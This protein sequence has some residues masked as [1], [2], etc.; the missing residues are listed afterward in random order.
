ME[1][2]GT[3][4]IVPDEQ[5]YKV[6]LLTPDQQIKRIVIFNGNKDTQLNLGDWFSEIEIND[7]NR[8]HTEVLFSDKC[9]HY[10]DTVRTIKRKVLGE[11]DPNALSYPE[12]YL[13]TKIKQDID[14]FH[15]YQTIT[16][17]DKNY[18]HS[19][20]LG[21]L[22]QN[23]HLP[24]EVTLNTPE[25]ETY[26][27]DDLLKYLPVVNKIHDVNIPIG[28]KFS[29]Y[30]DLLYSA[31]PFDI[32]SSTENPFTQTASNNLITY[33]KDLLLNYG[34]IVDNILYVCLIDDVIQYADEIGIGI[35]YMIQLYYPVMA[36][37]NVHSRQDIANLKQQLL[38][39]DQTYMN[40]AD[41][42]QYNA[43]I[44][45]LYKIYNNRK[46]NSE[47]P[48]IIKG[49]TEIDMTMHPKTSTI[50]P[51]EVI[52]KNIHT[53]KTVPFIKYNPGSRQENIYRLYCNK[54]SKNGK[55]IPL[56]KKQQIINYS[57][58]GNAREIFL[59]VKAVC[60]DDPTD[61]YIAINY[62]GNIRIQTTFVHHVST[63]ALN[64]FIKD[65]V[66]QL[67]DQF[68]VSLMPSGY[69]I[70][71]FIS[72]EDEL[73]EIENMQYAFEMQP[74]NSSLNFDKYLNCLTNIFEII[75]H[76]PN[77]PLIMNYKR[78]GNYAKMNSM[79][80]MIARVYTTTNSEKAVIDALILNFDMTEEQSLLEVVKFLNDFNQIN[81][82]YVNKSF[83]ILENQGFHTLLRNFKNEAKL[84]FTI[85]NINNIGF[86]DL[87]EI[88]LDSIFRIMQLPTSTNVSRDEIAQICLKK[89][90]I[91]QSDKDVAIIIPQ[92]N[93][94]VLNTD[95]KMRAEIIDEEDDD[96][97]DDAGIIFFDEEYEEDEDDEVGEPADEGPSDANDNV[98]EA[99]EVAEEVTDDADQEDMYGGAKKTFA[100]EET[101]PSNIFYNKMRRLDSDLILARKEGQFKA[102]SR[103]C[104]ANV[105]RQPIILT[106]DEKNRIDNENR[107]AYGYAMRYGHNTD[108]SKQNWFICPRYWCMKTNLPI[109][110]TDLEKTIKEG[111]CAREDIH[112]FTDP[113]YHIRNG[114]YVAHNPGLIKN[115]HPNNKGIPC[116]FGK[117]WDSEQLKT[118]RLKYG[119][120]E[121]D[122][123]D[124]NKQVDNKIQPPTAVANVNEFDNSKYYI[125]G[126][127]KYPI[128]NGRWGFLPPSVQLFLD[129]NYADVI[130]KKNAA[131]IKFNVNTFLRYGVEQSNHQ[132]FIG[133]IADIYAA[134]SRIKERNEA[135]PTIKRM[136][137][138][139]SKSIT[140][141]MYLQYQNGSLATL[142]QPKKNK[143]N[144]ELLV[145]YET[146]EFYKSLVTTDESQMGFFEET[147]GSF[148]NFLKYLNDD[149]SLIDHTYLWDIVT[150]VNPN[151]FPSGLNL[152]LLQIADNDI[153]DNVELICPTNS[154]MSNM[155]DPRRETVIILKHDTF[156]EPV[157]MYKI[158]K[159][160]EKETEKI[161]NT[162][163]TFSQQTA[164]PSLKRILNVVQNVMGK[165]CKARPSKPKEFIYKTNILAGDLLRLLKL[166]NYKVK[167]QVVNYRGKVIGLM[168][169][170]VDAKQLDLF[171][172]C[173]PSGPIKE[174]PVKY[175]DHIEWASY[176]NTRNA[177]MQVSEESNKSILS[178]P[179]LKVVEDELIVGILTETNQF[180]QIDPPISNDI[181][182]GLD[183]LYTTG[184]IN[185]GY[186]TADKELATNK[187]EDAE[188]LNTIHQINLEGQFYSAFRTTLRLA[189]NKYQNYEKRAQLLKLIDNK[190]YT[191]QH[192]LTRIELLVRSVL[193]DLVTFAEFNPDVLSTI[194]DISEIENKFVKSKYCIEIEDDNENCKLVIPKLNLVTSKENIVLYFKRIS[195][196]LLRYKRVRM[197]ILEPNKYLNI[198]SLD[199]KLNDNELLLIQTLLD[200]NYFDDL[201]EL[202][203][204]EYIDNITYDIAEPSVSQKYS[205]NISLNQQTASNAQPE[206]V[207]NFIIDCVVETLPNVIGNQTSYW[208]TV[209]PNKS[210]EVVFNNSTNCTYYVLCDII[211]KHR[212]KFVSIPFIKTALCQKY[213][214]HMETY[215]SQI[216]AILKSQHGKR[217]M[218][219]RVI[220]NQIKL[221]DLI[222]SEEYYITNL[223]L[224]AI[225]SH[226][227]LPIL[228]FS[229]KTLSNLG[230]G[231]QWV[232]L[233]GKRDVDN[234]YC[235]RSPVNNSELPEYHMITPAC[236]L[237][238][239]KGF[240]TMINNTDYIENN[241]SFETYLK[242]Y[243]LTADA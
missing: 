128:S 6:Y 138:I 32:L 156:Y 227:G 59:L 112:E 163:E 157:Y 54:L 90:I 21:Q 92:V 24:N 91:T 16:Q 27:Y 176:A 108:K 56:L 61:L 118:A 166:H 192:L 46:D 153:T 75:E 175:S 208:K 47:L 93:K 160:E 209:L 110:D 33:E 206:N 104:P 41:I 60:N 96:D 199:Y 188:R 226:L 64:Q 143:V 220:K 85:A 149:D 236:K 155:Y 222:M 119:V 12:L 22:M 66:N 148:E 197:F 142:F 224:W 74:L 154:Y 181:D 130:T 11:M 72:I 9:I 99:E 212:G 73:L 237:E 124:P 115:A 95:P 53:T 158:I 146:T 177:L 207:N 123:D 204:N 214:Q 10:D 144:A 8:N 178:M 203:A 18:F 69:K 179:M 218:I 29:T 35:D 31:N 55:K 30:R 43:N 7:I 101:E 105:N 162:T 50:L 65:T 233:G 134:V 147:V 84:S 137:E 216:L 132:S 195:D 228:L 78:V 172:P 223:D 5:V 183:A 196:E 239:I 151:L 117:R 173:F 200:G 217:E 98:E 45:T 23:L 37:H 80:S 121:D 139:L 113:K 187:Q 125:I 106:N 36:T 13:F 210:R 235:I 14:L 111:K 231:V 77:G 182:D 189:L 165:Y 193:K 159:D 240:D 82:R 109:K 83:D 131:L 58:L 120:A 39:D 49:I 38:M 234:Y 1:V 26:S 145:K 171:I 48:G 202:S 28:Q 20:M 2:T 141:D 52:F 4:N 238:Q 198:G 225:A 62:N 68:N 242:T 215:K 136:R 221:D 230:L 42:A 135:T 67:I 34:P 51:L 201:S 94:T 87:I 243:R 205:T 241:L 71:S 122:I 140:L 167:H 164:N 89:Q 129:I 57:K 150:S 44:D 180:V 76:S 81:G 103:T 133:C 114:E 194:S 116:C 126:F 170:I 186:I 232:V 86:I 190:Q 88:Y 169:I 107:D 15:I 191:Y 184:Y 25:Q 174:I 211:N 213:N 3:M 102:Y 17:N 97:D 127:D 219:T 152:I 19:N 168:A 70:N 161:T 79:Q 63:D 40:N 100:T 229:Q 185:N